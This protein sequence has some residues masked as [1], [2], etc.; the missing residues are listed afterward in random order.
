VGRRR[1][2]IS[3]AELERKR[4]RPELLLAV[5]A[6]GQGA[7]VRADIVPSSAPPMVL[8]DFLL[9][10]MLQ[11]MIGRPRRP[12]LMHVKGKAGRHHG[13]RAKGAIDALCSPVAMSIPSETQGGQQVR[14]P[15]SNVANGEV[16]F[17]EAGSRR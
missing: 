2:D 8:A 11:P 3:I 7:V 10:A 17:R 4:E 9:G 5:H 1:L 6:S 14:G 15:G 12:Q 13:V 16:L